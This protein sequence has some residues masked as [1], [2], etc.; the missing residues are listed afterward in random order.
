[1]K[2]LNFN[3]NIKASAAKVWQVLWNDLTYRKW[4]SV[5]KEGSYAVSDWKEGSKILFLSPDGSGMYSIIEQSRPNEYMA[6][7][8]IGEIKNFE[9]QPLDETTKLWSGGLEAYTL[10][11]ENG[12]TTLHTDLD[13]PQNFLDYFNDNFPKALALV[14][15]LAEN[16]IVL[17][18]EATVDATI[19]QIWEYWTE[20]KHIMNWNTAS[21]DWFTPRAENDLRVGGQFS[22]RMEARDGSF[23]F[24]FGGT[25]TTVDHHKKIAYVMSDG[26]RVSIDFV[27]QDKDYKIT[28]SFD[29]EETNSLELQ[30]DGWQAIMNSYKNYTESSTAKAT[31]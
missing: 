24:D 26:R 10:K 9:E 6:F 4:T 16:P 11:E 7:R 21:P 19:Q 1:M 20:P 25:Y 13:A 28:E 29:A 17:T 27:K 14:K 18:V 23:G 2:K 5:F 15:E 8:H 12:I 30:Q 31:S 22:S 3:I